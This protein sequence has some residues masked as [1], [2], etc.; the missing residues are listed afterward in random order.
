M[1]TSKTSKPSSQAKSGGH[2]PAAA[3]A[4]T[5]AAPSASGKTASSGKSGG[6]RK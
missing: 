2:K 4:R 1:K 5:G 6:P 3:R